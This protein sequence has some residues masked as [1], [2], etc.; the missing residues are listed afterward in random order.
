MTG[1]RGMLPDTG[2]LIRP[3]LCFPRKEIEAYLSEK[4]EEYVVDSTNLVSDYRRNFLRNEITAQSGISVKYSG[5]K[6]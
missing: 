6:R 3:L 1:L 4:G 5:M 2:E